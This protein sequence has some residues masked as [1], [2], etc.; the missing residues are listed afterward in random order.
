[1]HENIALNNNNNITLLS[2]KNLTE[3][4]CCVAIHITMQYMYNFVQESSMRSVLDIWVLI[5]KQN[6]HKTYSFV[7]RGRG[8]F[9]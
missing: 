2:V 4:K 6:I 3:L 9:I 7:I 1:M 5:L 8:F